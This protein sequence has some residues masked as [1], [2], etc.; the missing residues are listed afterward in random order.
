MAKYWLTGCA[1]ALTALAIATTECHSAAP[2]SPA[3]NVSPAT[4]AAPASKPARKVGIEILDESFRGL[5]APD[6]PLRP[7]ARERKFVEGPV[8]LPKAACLIFSDIPAEMIC[9]WT[10]DEGVTV[11]RQ[12]SGGANGNAMDRDGNVLSCEHLSRSLTRRS[13]DGK[14]ETL[15]STYKGKKLNSPNDVTV[16]SDGTIWFTDPP[17]GLAKGQAPEQEANYVFRLDVGATEPVAVAADLS[18]PNGLCF[19]PGEKVLYI[20]DSD[21]P[22]V[23]HIRKFT[24]N[25]DNTLSG[26]EV[27]AT[28]AQGEGVA[29]G[30]RCDRQGRLFAACGDG[31]QVFNADGNLIGKIHTPEYATNCCFGGP[32]GKTLFITARTSVW[33][34]DLLVAP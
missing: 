14:V 18:R 21:Y 33:A 28:I 24:V 22:K 5:I 19:G 7:V 12:P 32:D 15:C 31:V 9:R 13:A 2:T 29:D 8:W 30:I 27:F 1:A 23:H 25:S 34:V 11:F 20:S 16:K 17:Y 4:R 3:T 26:G 6:A 10:A